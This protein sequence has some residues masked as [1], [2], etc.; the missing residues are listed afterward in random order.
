VQ[1]EGDKMKKISFAEIKCKFEYAG[2]WIEEDDSLKAIIEQECQDIK[3]YIGAYVVNNEAI[4][5]F[6]S[7][8]NIVNYCS[9]TKGGNDSKN[10]QLRYKNIIETEI[11]KGNIVEI[12]VYKS[13]CRD[14]STKANRNKIKKD[15]QNTVANKDKDS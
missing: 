8:N 15:F 7:G 10:T 4:C 5:F 1:V 13:L 11:K 6:Q 14:T 2:K 9:N 3:E 12:Y